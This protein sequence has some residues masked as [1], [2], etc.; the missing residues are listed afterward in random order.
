MQSSMC[1]LTIKSRCIESRELVHR[2]IVSA[3]ELVAGQ[4]AGPSRLSREVNISEQQVMR[5]AAAPPGRIMDAFSKLMQHGTASRHDNNN[6]YHHQREAAAVA[7]RPAASSLVARNGQICSR[8]P[9]VI[10][11]IVTWHEIISEI[12]PPTP[13]LPR[14]LYLLN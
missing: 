6:M 4:E 12:K 11:I 9:C 14:P 8:G 7:A 5:S 10:V 2:T 3:A 1:L 13:P